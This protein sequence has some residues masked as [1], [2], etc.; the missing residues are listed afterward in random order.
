[1]AAKDR[2]AAAAQ[3]NMF[4]RWHTNMHPL[5]N[6]SSLGP[7]PQTASRPVHLLQGITGV[8]KT[9]THRP[10]SVRRLQQ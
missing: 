1:M 8:P 6:R 2:I 7:T 9:E 10:R 3:I 5:F 4:A